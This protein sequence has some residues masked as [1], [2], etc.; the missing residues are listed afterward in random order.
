MRI[1][2]SLTMKIVL[3]ILRLAQ[4][5][6]TVFDLTNFL[7]LKTTDFFSNKRNSLGVDGTG[8]T[9]MTI[10]RYFSVGR[11]VVDTPE[12]AGHSFKKN[13]VLASYKLAVAEPAPSLCITSHEIAMHEGQCVIC[14]FSGHDQVDCAICSESIDTNVMPIVSCSV[15]L[16]I[17]T[18]FHYFFPGCQTCMTSPRFIAHIHMS[19]HMSWKLMQYYSR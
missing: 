10:G 12:M 18:T 15:P 7:E 8:L 9:S 1:Y 3:G 4:C 14:D 19:P 6:F 17:C 11:T 2:L 5:A 13:L 16:P